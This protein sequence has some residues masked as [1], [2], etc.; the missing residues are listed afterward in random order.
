MTIMLVTTP[1]RPT[2]TNFPPIG[3][4]NIINY[5]QKHD[6]EVDFYHIDALRPTFEEAVQYVI[7]AKPDVLGVSSVVSTAYDYT[8]RF[9]SAIKAA[10]PNTLVIVGGSLAASAEILLRCANVDLCC[11]G[12]GEKVMLNVA[13]RAQSTLKA[14]DYK[15]ISGLVLLDETGKLVNTGYETQLSKEEIYDVNWDVLEHSCDISTYVHPIAVDGEV[16]FWFKQDERTYEQAREGKNITSLAAAKGCVARC[17][18][19][20]RWDKGIRYIP[21]NL[22]KDRIQNL[23]DRY[24]VGFLNIVDE[25]FGTDKRWLTEFCATLKSFGILWRVAGMRV[26]CITPEYIEMMK[27]AGC[28]AILYGMETGSEKILQIMEKKVKLQ[29]N[30]NAMKWTVDAGQ[31]TIVQL[32]IG[33]PGESPSTIRETADFAAYANSIAVTQRP[34]DLSINY[35]QALPGTPLYE[36]ARRLGLIGKTLEDEEKYLL[37]ISDRDAA[38][39]NMTI[40]FTAYPGFIH[41]SWRHAIQLK[42][43]N[44][45]IKKFGKE[46]YTKMLLEDTRYF[47]RKKSSETGYFNEP[48]KKVDRIQISDG[49]KKEDLFMVN[50]NGQLPPLVSLIKKRKFGITLLCYPEIFYYFIWSL[51]FIY[52]L[53]NLRMHGF[54]HTYKDVH[55]WLSGALMRQRGNP[56]KS[57]RKVVFNDFEILVTDAVEMDPLRKGR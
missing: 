45:Y 55:N 3:S 15:D 34:W 12:E 39:E 43:A 5:L 42:T 54:K 49:V 48:K 21:A 22:L 31:S 19:C 41:Q 27:D 7:D 9:V 32:V 47:S 16:D 29:D 17:T 23:V 18:F 14:A 44:A 2:P 28:V 30:L 56:E 46:P 26:N 57:L 36:Y 24:N 8:Q 40:N 53:K 51:P 38:D 37:K 25:N 4:L 35:A 1:I 52:F 10:L 13:K 33:M 11:S 6:F 50:E 20:H